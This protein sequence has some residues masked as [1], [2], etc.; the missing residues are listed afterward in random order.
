MTYPILF[1]NVAASGSFID[2]ILGS[3]NDGSVTLTSASTI[4]NY[5]SLS[6]TVNS[7]S[8]SVTLSAVNNLSAGD[9][10]MFHQTQY[11]SNVNYVGTHELA[12]IA[13]VNPA[14]NSVT[15]TTPLS[16][17]YYSGTFN[18]SSA[19]VAQAIRVPNYYSVNVSENIA[20]FAWNGIIGG[21]IVMKCLNTITVNSGVQINS[22]GSG[23]RGGDSSVGADQGWAFG[24]NGESWNGLGSR[25]QS[26]NNGG[27]GSGNL[28]AG[29]QMW[30]SGGGGGGHATSGGSGG[31]GGTSP[32]TTGSCSGMSRT[33]GTGGGTYGVNTLARITYGSGSGTA[34]DTPCGGHQNEPRR[35]GGGA[36]FLIADSINVLGSLNVRGQTS[37]QTGRSLNGGGAGGSILIKAKTSFT[38]SGN[39]YAIGG[40]GMPGSVSGSGGDGPSGAGGQGRVAIY[41]PSRTLGSIEVTP[42]E[43]STV[44]A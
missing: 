28:G 1:G 27:G 13:S 31:P 8:T 17:T 43:S 37:T 29:G 15:L 23:Y 16:N 22:L 26:P 7:G 18:S 24:Q 10:L 41:S 4:N 5:Y 25:S 38:N 6:S 40:D 36:I 30:P 32:N 42:F 33:G 9:E 35:A 2:P 39:I 20:P 12:R 34:P 3:G 14:N 44:T 11:S 21:I 19:S